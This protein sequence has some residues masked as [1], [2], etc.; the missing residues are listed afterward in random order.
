MSGGDYNQGGFAALL[1]ATGSIKDCYSE[2]DITSSS[3][4][5]GGFVGSFG[6]AGTITN[7]YSNGSISVHGT[8]NG[9]CGCTRYWISASD[10]C[11]GA[12]AVAMR[13]RLKNTKPI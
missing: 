13:L 7:C 10:S 3:G 5:T 9:F 4:D 12:S 11:S 8:S 2:T 6:G 1:R